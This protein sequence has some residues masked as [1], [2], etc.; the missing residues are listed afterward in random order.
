[1]SRKLNRILNPLSSRKST[2]DLRASS[3]NNTQGGRAVASSES[4]EKAVARALDKRFST[5]A[6]TLSETLISEQDNEYETNEK[7]DLILQKLES[8][9]SRLGYVEM[10]CERVESLCEDLEDGIRELKEAEGTRT[11]RGESVDV[12]LLDSLVSRLEESSQFKGAEASKEK[13]QARKPAADLES[14]A[15]RLRRIVLNEGD[16]HASGVVSLAA[17][18]E[19]IYSSLENIGNRLETIEKQSSLLATEVYSVASRQSDLKREIIT[20]ATQQ[21]VPASSATAP[22]ATSTEISEL[23]HRLVSIELNMESL[24]HSYIESLDAALIKQTN[25]F[26][27]I[28]DDML[29][30]PTLKT[31]ASR[32]QSDSPPSKRSSILSNPPSPVPTLL[33]KRSSYRVPDLGISSHLSKLAG[34]FSMSGGGGGRPETPSSNHVNVND[35]HHDVPESVAGD[36]K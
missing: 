14:L 17:R 31:R 23:S 7:L 22:P 5:L 13:Q 35:L 34:G 21:Q 33:N 32:S 28:V 25:M 15:S 36:Q 8:L 24:A 3:N 2:I 4:I 18:L 27:N 9:E 12:V 16:E 20:L 10:S 19:K 30:D 11:P 29:K 6:T 1:M 26:I